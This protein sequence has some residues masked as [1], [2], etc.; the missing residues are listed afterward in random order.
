MLS[1][2]QKPPVR[3]AFT[4]KMN[5]ALKQ[6]TSEATA[7]LPHCTPTGTQIEQIAVPSALSNLL[8]ATA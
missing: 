4:A 2:W 5:H 7:H 1:H 6:S 8:A 3:T